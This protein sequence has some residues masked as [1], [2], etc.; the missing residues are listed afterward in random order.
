MDALGRPCSIGSPTHDAAACDM[1]TM[2]FRDA[3]GSWGFLLRRDVPHHGYGVLV[4]LLVTA[5]Y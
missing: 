5:N 4:G 2:L 3:K 1:R